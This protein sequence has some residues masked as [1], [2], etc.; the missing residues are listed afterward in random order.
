MFRIKGKPGEE[1]R[2]RASLAAS[3]SIAVF[4]TLA[5]ALLPG[6]ALAKTGRTHSPLCNQPVQHVTAPKGIFRVIEA[7]DR[8]CAWTESLS[9]LRAAEARASPAHLH[10]VAYDLEP[11]AASGADRNH[12]LASITIFAHRAHADGF[13]VLMTPWTEWTHADLNE[14]VRRSAQVGD[15]LD[16][17]IQG[18]ECDPSRFGAA[19]RAANAIVDRT[20]EQPLIVNQISSKGC[21]RF[22][23]SDWNA[24]RP[25]VEGRWVWSP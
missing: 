6:P 11:W 1:I 16:L 10:W 13:R 20:K 15:M 25:W 21:R 2:T 22:L 9:G 5:P 14:I 8:A 18:Y 4:L 7:V 24:A 23:A 17:Q 12:P 19:A 3:L